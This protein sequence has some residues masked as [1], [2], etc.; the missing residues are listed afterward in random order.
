M[1]LGKD[2][3]TNKKRYCPHSVPLFLVPCMEEGLSDTSGQRTRKKVM[4]ATML[5]GSS[6]S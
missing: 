1:I 2:Q 6:S 3:A 5:G 4:D